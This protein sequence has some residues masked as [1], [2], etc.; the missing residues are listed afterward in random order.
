MRKI[1]AIAA[2]ALVYVALP[3]VV[4]GQ[5]HATPEEVV[6]KVREAA[7]TLSKTGDLTPFTQK[8]GPWVWKDTYVFV[9]DCDK[10]VVAAN[11]V[12]PDQVGQDFGTI[13]DTRGRRST[14][15]G[16]PIAMP[17]RS[18]PATGSSIGGRSPVRRRVRARSA[19]T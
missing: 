12:R 19:F 16:K 17:R 1:F 7:S 13:K 6:A 15:T 2:L 18:L 3:M 14:R 9:N 5:D 10:K 4:V 8:N 11:I